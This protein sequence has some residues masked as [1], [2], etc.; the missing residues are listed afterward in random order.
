MTETGT[1]VPSI[2]KVEQLAQALHVSPSWLA[3]G[4]GEQD[5]ALHRRSRGAVSATVT[6]A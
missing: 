5:F 6:P 4:I 3:F 2:A 1:T